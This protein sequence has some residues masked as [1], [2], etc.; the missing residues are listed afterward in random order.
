M[1]KTLRDFFIMMFQRAQDLEFRDGFYSDYVT[2][3]LSRDEVPLSRGEFS[4]KF[5]A[6]FQLAIA[7][8]GQ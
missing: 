5:E 2:L 1:D 3:C 4:Y 8:F 6:G 7:G